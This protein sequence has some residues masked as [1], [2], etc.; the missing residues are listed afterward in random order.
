MLLNASLVDVMQV[1]R[2]G[3]VIT[4][5]LRSDPQS[6]RTHC[7]RCGA[8]TMDH[9][10]TCGTELP[11]ALAGVDLIPIGAMPPPRAC[12]TCGAVFPWARKPRPAPEP[13]ATIEEMLRRLPRVVRELRWRHT[14]KPPLTIEE[15]R[16]LEDL[17]RAL[18]TLRFDEVRLE[19]RAPL[20]SQ[21]NRCDLFLVPGGIALTVKIVRPDRR[22]AQLAEQWK[23]DIA[24]YQQRGGCRVLVGYFHDP[25][26]LLRDQQALPAL[27]PEVLEVRCVI[28]SS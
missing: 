1:C 24:Y 13:L 14:G 9:C 2:N 7:E 5:R 22:E 21:V 6:G 15:E 28:G 12:P 16:D 11:G 26:G 3:H 19:N 20:Y 25:E 4:D 27:A 8:S 10:S 23:E 18:L 17:L